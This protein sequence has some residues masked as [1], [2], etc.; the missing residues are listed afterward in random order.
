VFDFRPVSLAQI[1]EHLWRRGRL[2][3]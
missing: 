2:R 3:R 1:R